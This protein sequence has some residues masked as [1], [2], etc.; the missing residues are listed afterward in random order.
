M[1][2]LPNI[3]LTQLKLGSF[4]RKCELT[5]RQGEGRFEGSGQGPFSLEK[6]KGHNFTDSG[7]LKGSSSGGRTGPTQ[8]RGGREAR[9]RLRRDAARTPTSGRAWPLPEARALRVRPAGR[10]PQEPRPK[11]RDPEGETDP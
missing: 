7:C 6:Q 5:G 9:S 3:P 8:G 10:A 4:K 11:S 2:I 1:E